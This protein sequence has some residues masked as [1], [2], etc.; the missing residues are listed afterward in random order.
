MIGAIAGDIIGS[1]YE[2]NGIKTKEFPLFSDRSRFTDDTVLTVAVAHAIITGTPYLDSIRKL[3]QSYPDAGY[4]GSFIRWL[5]SEKATPY[6][7][8]GNGSAMRVSPVGFAFSTE[9]EVLEQARM[10]A[11]I[12][13]NH[14]EGI[15]GARAA[16]LAI[17]VARTTKDKEAVRLHIKDRFG[18]NLDRS[19][20][21]IRPA[22]SFDI[23]CQGTVPEAIISFLDSESYEDAVRNAV[24]LGGDSDTLACITGGIAEAYYGEVPMEIYSKVE[25]I[26]TPD[27][28]DVAISFREKYILG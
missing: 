20:D 25:E 9:N 28:M 24:S 12:T 2:H 26:L 16:A 13:H 19:V 3:G 15:K 11:E 23:S 6:N 4:G 22:Y 10:T 7:S 5:F 1:V 14:P 27:L 21:E 17:F 18:Y 8:W